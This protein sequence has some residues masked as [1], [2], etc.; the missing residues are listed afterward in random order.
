MKKFKSADKIKVIFEPGDRNVY[1]LPGFKFA[2]ALTFGQA[3]ISGYDKSGRF[4]DNGDHLTFPKSVK[5][6]KASGVIDSAVLLKSLMECFKRKIS[7]A[8]TA[9]AI[10]ATGKQYA[11]DFKKL[12]SLGS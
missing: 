12:A 11:L 9:A 7:D 10:D 1:D 4:C 2:L 5:L 6:G 8:D 3:N